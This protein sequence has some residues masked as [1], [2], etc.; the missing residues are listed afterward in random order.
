MFE[1]HILYIQ[2][3]SVYIYMIPTP[4]RWKKKGVGDLR[5]ID[6]SFWYIHVYYPLVI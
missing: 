5:K 1:F 4:L 2:L 6:Y 3:Q